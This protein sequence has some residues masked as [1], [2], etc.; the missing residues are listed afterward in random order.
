MKKILMLFVLACVLFVSCSKEKKI[1]I[2]G[3]ETT[4]IPYGWA[5]AA[6][7]NDSVVYKVSVDDVLIS[8]ILS[9]TIVVP[10][11][12]TGWYLFEPVGKNNI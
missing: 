7:K 12:S 11:L 8:I 9:E 10:I 5:N 2:N 6:E 1:V 3:K 4:V